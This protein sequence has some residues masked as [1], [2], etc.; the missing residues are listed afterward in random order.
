ML[1]QCI[2]PFSNLHRYDFAVKSMANHLYGSRVQYELSHLLQEA[3]N[4]SWNTGAG[5]QDQANLLLSKGGSE[6]HIIRQTQRISLEY[7][8]KT[9]DIYRPSDCSQNFFK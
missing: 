8:H 6:Q 3:F 1:S 5:N 4:G 7:L 2:L 9:N